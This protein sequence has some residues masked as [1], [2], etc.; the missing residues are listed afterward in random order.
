MLGT[1]VE[2]DAAKKLHGTSADSVTSAY[3]IVP[4]LTP[5]TL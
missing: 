2:M 1:P 3:G 5:A 4:L